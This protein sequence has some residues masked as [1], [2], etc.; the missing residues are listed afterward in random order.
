MNRSRPGAIGVPI[1][2]LILV[3]GGL[4][5][6]AA[7]DLR[8]LAKNP[9]DW[10]PLAGGARGLLSY[11]PE[12][13]TFRFRAQGLAAQSGYALI[14]HNDNP[15]EGQVLAVGRSDD[16][17]R[18]HLQGAWRLWRAKFWLLPVADLELTG[19]RAELKAWHP[20]QYLFE[21]RILE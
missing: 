13:G 20:R 11:D 16:A 6:A 3:F 9:A 12:Q 19:D 14:H 7:Q 4:V 2:L 5:P 21:S 18:L 17:G 15:R 10:Q 8:L 1:L